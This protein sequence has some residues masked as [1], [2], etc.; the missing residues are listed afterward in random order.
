MPEA[1]AYL[2]VEARFTILTAHLSQCASRSQNFQS[3]EISSPKPC[4]C[5]G[6]HQNQSTPAR[7]LDL[8]VLRLMGV[9]FR[10]F[11][12]RNAHGFPFALADVLA[13]VKNLANMVGIM[14][15]LAVDGLQ[16]RV[17]FHATEDGG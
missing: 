3:R 15:H 13:Q 10:R 11:S 5:R 1:L 9:V 6:S 2:W 4:C 8:A 14:C 17:R 16:H 12:F 7:S